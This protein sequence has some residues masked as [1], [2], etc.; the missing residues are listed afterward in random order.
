MFVDRAR[1]KV[2]G[3]KGGDGCVSF[4]REKYVPRGGPDGGDGGNGGSVIFRAVTGEQSLVD[5]YHQPHR[6]AGKGQ[7]GGGKGQHGSKG[8]DKVVNVPVGILVRDVETGAILADLAE[9]NQEYVA[10][11]GGKGGRGNTRFVTATRRAPR[12]SDPGEPGPPLRAARPGPLR[13]ARGRWRACRPTPGPPTRSRR[14]PSATSPT[15]SA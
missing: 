5:I 1:T 12:L 15:C 3:G 4:R 13:A 11:H 8:K 7:H 14:F 10:A 9:E 2:C 6:Q